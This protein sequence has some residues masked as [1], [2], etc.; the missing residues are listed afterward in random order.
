MTKMKKV[1][2]LVLAF[3]M[4][5]SLFS[6]LSMTAMATNS[7]EI[8]LT[9]I[10]ANNETAENTYVYGEKAVLKG[11]SVKIYKDLYYG[12]PGVEVTVAPGTEIDLITAYSF[13]NGAVVYRFDYWG[14]ESPALYDAVLDYCF[15]PATEFEGSEDVAPEVTPQ[16]T[17]TP[18]VEEGNAIVDFGSM[19]RTMYIS[20]SRLTLY[21][22]HMDSVDSKTVSN[23]KGEKVKVYFYYELADGTVKYKVEYTGRKTALKNAIASGYEFVNAEDL[24]AAKSSSKSGWYF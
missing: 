24:S 3:V 19:N 22:N 20:P 9:V 14:S 21:S 11:N 12:A 1:L 2:S 6:G 16:P 18:D 17:P 5:L 13:S 15:I 23:V 7:D 10:P 8:T 4:T